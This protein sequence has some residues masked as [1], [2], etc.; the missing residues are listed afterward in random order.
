MSNCFTAV[1]EIPFSEKVSEVMVLKLGVFFWITFLHKL[2]FEM[3]LQK[4]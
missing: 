2:F 3:P 1:V 4:T